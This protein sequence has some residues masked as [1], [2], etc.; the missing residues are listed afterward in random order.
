MV[1]LGGAV[2]SSLRYA[3]TLLAAQLGMQSYWGTMIVNALGS[4]AIGALSASL[5]SQTL[6]LFLVVG[7]CG[8]FTTYSTFS[9]QTITLLQ[10]GNLVTA[11]LYIALT[12]IICLLSTYAGWKLCNYIV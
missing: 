9:L 5:S 1:A 6:S 11:M 4:F 10:Q 2:G 7:L 8:G 12:L 3:I